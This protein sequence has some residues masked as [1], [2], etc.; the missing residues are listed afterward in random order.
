MVF[1]LQQD[2]LSPRCLQP[3]PLSSRLT[4]RRWSGS[5]LKVF[6]V[7]QTLGFNSANSQLYHF[8]Q[9]CVEH[10]AQ[11]LPYSKCSININWCYSHPFP[12]PLCMNF[13]N[14]WCSFIFLPHSKGHPGDSFN[15]HDAW[16]CQGTRL[17]NFLWQEPWTMPRR[18]SLPCPFLVGH[19]R[20]P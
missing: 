16:W 13:S 2:N 18:P 7:F 3:P 12:F 6:G 5:E 19:W 15:L 10:S 9:A 4:P 20:W 8:W 1:L 14:S 11:C 17:Q